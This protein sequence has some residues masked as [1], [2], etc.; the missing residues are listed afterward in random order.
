MIKK[1]AQ[2]TLEYTLVLVAILL[3][4]LAAIAPQDGPIRKGVSDFLKQTGESI[5]GIVDNAL[6]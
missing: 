2:S 4:L 5:G 1:K 3:G 6:K